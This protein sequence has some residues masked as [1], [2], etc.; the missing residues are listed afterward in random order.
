[1]KPGSYALGGAKTPL[2]KKKMKA[3]RPTSG[4]KGKRVSVIKHHVSFTE[5][6]ML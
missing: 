6:D 4:K 2:P 1:M 3:G 5:A